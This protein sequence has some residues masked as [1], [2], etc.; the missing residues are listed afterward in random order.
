MRGRIISALL[1]WLTTSAATEAADLIEVPAAPMK[2]FE[3]PYVL[4]VPK[5]QEGGPP[6][7][8]LIEP[9]DTGVVDDNLEV[10][11]AAA[12]HA[13]K[14][15]G[16]GYSVAS[17]LGIPLLVPVFPRPKSMENVYTHSLDRDTILIREGSLRR[18]DLQLI[19]MAEDAKHR[20]ADL[21]RPVKSKF[22]INGFSASGLFANRFTFLHPEVV[23]G[24]AYGGLNGFIMVPLEERQS[25]R[26]EFPLGLA[27][28]KEITGHSFDRATYSRI[29]QFAYMGELDDNDA[30]LYDDAYPEPERSLVFELFSRKMM[31]ERWEAV[32]AVYRQQ[33]LP[34]E[35]KTYVGIG[36]GTNGKIHTE[37]ADFYRKAMPAPSEK[38]NQT[39]QPT[40][41]PR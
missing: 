36:H 33:K 28:Y 15:S 9:N 26:L 19:A 30:V 40:A 34:V 5:Q 37:V 2:G 11:H 8:L 4:F 14:G 21:G 31:P 24:A 27:D 32:Q 20:L 7:Y 6:Q 41:G 25:R 10:H 22:L 35:F 17:H 18:I 39:M 23:A 3:F 16:V 1:A 12:T 29:P 13:A 38:P